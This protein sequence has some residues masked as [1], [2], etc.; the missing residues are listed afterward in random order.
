VATRCGIY[1]RVSTNEQTCEPQ[2]NELR[3]Y[4]QRRGWTAT[5]YVDTGWS[6]VKD[7]RPQLNRL[8][9]DCRK[10]RLDIVLVYRFD[11]FAR[12]VRQLVVALEEFRT[13]GIDFV[14]LHEGCDTSTA[15]GRLVF[16]IFASIA[17]FERELIRDRVRSGLAAARK[18]GKRLGRPSA[19]VDV[20][21]ITALRAA[22]TPW[23]A[24]AKQLG[25]AS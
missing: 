13:L 10:R 15:N 2:L 1:A 8:L 6:G 3:E 24:L 11:R 23:R 7:N 16:N 18:R 12:S 19:A 5:E 17:E 9:T 20:A 21:R 14:S 22:G 25:L 4:A